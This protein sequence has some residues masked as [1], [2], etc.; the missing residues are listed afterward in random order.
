[1]AIPDTELGKSV[2]S[3]GV[4]V[5]VS[6]DA[7]QP[8]RGHFVLDL[9]GFTPPHPPELDGFPFGSY[10]RAEAWFD[11]DRALSAV[12]LARIAVT[13]GAFELVGNGLLR[14]L[15]PEHASA[16][17]R[18]KGQ[19]PCTALSGAVAESKLGR[20]YGNWV[21]S[22]ASQLVQGS[23]DVTVELQADTRSIEQSRFVKRIGVGCGLRPLSVGQALS[24]GLPPLPD[25]D[26]FRH[27]AHQLPQFGINVPPLPS[28]KPP[29]WWRNR[30][31]NKFAD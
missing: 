26:T 19:I 31:S 15:L 1:V 18:L 20:T 8:L 14:L 11:V 4:I 22:H 21:R 16:Q 13:S 28:I 3:G 2:A 10:T 9:M 7:L 23:V 29:D 5:S 6:R 25:A 27:L 24:L 12:N 30:N 17:V